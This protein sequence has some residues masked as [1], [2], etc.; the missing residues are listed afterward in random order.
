MYYLKI[1]KANKY[2]IILLQKQHYFYNNLHLEIILKGSNINSYS[3][4]FQIH[5]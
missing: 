4:P 1:L 3:K 2:D 5:L